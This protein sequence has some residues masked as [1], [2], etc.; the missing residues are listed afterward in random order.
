VKTVTLYTRVDCHLCEEA[1]AAL[2]RVRAA[3]PFALAVIDLD[4]EAPDDKLRAYTGEV[5]VVELEGRKV[6]KYQVDEARL[7]R[8]LASG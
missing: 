2:E 5:P 8:L 4:R 7:M 3:C 1:H 6:M